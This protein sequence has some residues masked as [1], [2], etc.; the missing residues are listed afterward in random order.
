MTSPVPSATTATTTRGEPY[1]QTYRVVFRIADGRGAE[2][3]ENCDI[4]LVGRVLD[5]VTR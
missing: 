3:V 4:A 5:P 1:E 2:I